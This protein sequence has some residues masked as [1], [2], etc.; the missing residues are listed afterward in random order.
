[1]LTKLPNRLFLLPHVAD[2]SYTHARPYCVLRKLWDG[3]M[4]KNKHLNDLFVL[5]SKVKHYNLIMQRCT[6]HWFWLIKGSVF[7]WIAPIIQLICA[8]DWLSMNRRR[9][10]L[11]VKWTDRYW[12]M[13][14]EHWGHS[15]SYSKNDVIKALWLAD[16][17]GSTFF[18]S[19]GRLP[20]NNFLW[21]GTWEIMGD[22]LYITSCVITAINGLIIKLN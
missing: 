16:T 2:M 7:L 20:Q 18:M 10:G 4:V 3:S 22:Q 9:N 15:L 14:G 11:R 19:I 17:L 13:H 6:I 8:G 12:A 21:S 5:V 1:M